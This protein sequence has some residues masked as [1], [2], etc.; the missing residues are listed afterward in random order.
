MRSLDPIM[1]K[2]G[3]SEE[4]DH[5][6]NSTAVLYHKVYNDFKLVHISVAG[7]PFKGMYRFG[8]CIAKAVEQSEGDAVFLASGDLSHKLAPRS[9]RLSMI[10]DRS[11]TAGLVEY[12]RVPDRRVD[13]I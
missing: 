8:S 1:A 4:L 7:L 2:Y 9:L 6:V 10:A 11:L 12:L 3:I 13:G 5:G